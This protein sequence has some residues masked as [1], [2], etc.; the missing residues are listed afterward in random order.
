MKGIIGDG[1]K[2]FSC[3]KSPDAVWHGSAANVFVCSACAVFVLPA[4]I[5]DAVSIPKSKN[6]FN[7]AQLSIG[8][9]TSTF[10]KAMSCSFL[11]G[12]D[13]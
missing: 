8:E 10:W 4:L 2:C 12:G 9:V 6:G 5:A 3:G 1:E 13:K 7:S 11:F